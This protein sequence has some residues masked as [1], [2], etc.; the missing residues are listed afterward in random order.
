MTTWLSITRSSGRLF[1]IAT[2]THTVALILLVLTFAAPPVFGQAGEDGP[3]IDAGLL[4]AG[5]GAPADGAVSIHGNLA[6]VGGSEVAQ[7]FARPRRGDAWSDVARLTVTD[8]TTGFG[9]S[10]AISDDTVVVGA[11]DAVYVFRATGS[12]WRQVA[13]LTPSESNPELAFGASVAVS[14]ETIVIGAPTKLVVPVHGS[15]LTYVFERG[16]RDHDW[17]Q[18]AVL[19]P[20]EIF[21]GVA[22]NNLFG[23]DVSVNGDTL[24][25]GGPWRLSLPA[26]FAP[27]AHVFVRDHGSTAP[28]RA[29]AALTPPLAHF[30]ADAPLPA[31]HVAVD[32]DTAL[33]G[34]GGSFASIRIYGRDVGGP[35]A[36]REVTELA[37]TA[38]RVDDFGHSL[39]F[40]G[41]TAA[42]FS[43]LEGPVG[44]ATY[45]VFSRNEGHAE[46]WGQTARLLPPS[47]GS[48][49]DRAIAV[50]GDTIMIG[51]PLQVYL[52]DIDRD[53]VRDARDECP[54]DPLETRPGGCQRDSLTSPVL[55][56]LLTT[57]GVIF[58]SQY[59]RLTIVVTFRNQSDT[60]VR[61]PFF[62]VVELGNGNV[63]VNADGT[64]NRVGATLSPDVGDGDLSPGESM[65]VTFDLGLRNRDAFEFRVAFHGQPV[66]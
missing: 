2:N 35:N 64:R 50:N 55:D 36:W 47:A 57:E 4:R 58:Q 20:P 54:R 38:G 26:L 23:A 28:W 34:A 5:D 16:R 7:V 19:T 14:G 33:F 21:T 62:E 32:A 42:V 1:R 66:E 10:V 39:A 18:T 48:P 56:E 24:V 8:G 41:D 6:V 13:R 22:F 15:G 25:V 27:V 53:T 17:T 11:T 12:R 37:P 51:S 43:P 65:T 30:S 60:R 45:D 9:T 61:N 52:S 31:A 46:G 29:V 44:S 59:R 3:F 40:D 63:L 49:A